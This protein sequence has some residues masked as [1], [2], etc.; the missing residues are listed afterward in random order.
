MKPTPLTTQ[1]IRD[2]ERFIAV[3]NGKITWDSLVE[4]LET[5]Q[6]LKTTRQRLERYPSIKEAYLRA[7]ARARGKGNGQEAAALETFLKL[8]KSDRDLV[9]Q[10][11]AVEA[12]KEHF[13][14]KS[15][16][17]FAVIDAILKKCATNRQLKDAVAEALIRAKKEK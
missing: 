12:E 2:I 9:E 13:K 3:W 4:Q 1:Q 5:F 15:E 10:Y 14:L 16:Q 8:S 7:K 11:R 6:S 17:Q